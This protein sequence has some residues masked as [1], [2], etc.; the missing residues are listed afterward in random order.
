MT[1]HPVYSVYCILLQ[2]LTGNLLIMSSRNESSKMRKMIRL[3][4]TVMS[5]FLQNSS[6]KVGSTIP[7]YAVPLIHILFLVVRLS[8]SSRSGWPRT[9]KKP[10]KTLN[11]LE[12]YQALNLYEKYT[13]ILE[14]LEKV[15]NFI[16]LLVYIGYFVIF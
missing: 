10:W 16:L 7:L 9:F 8:F 14:N 12:F 5:T 2:L 15:L 11:N 3:I 13:K 1:M 4:I 6:K